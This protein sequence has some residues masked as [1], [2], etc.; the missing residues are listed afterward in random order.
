[1]VVTILKVVKAEKAALLAVRAARV[2]VDVIAEVVL[3]VVVA[4]MDPAVLKAAAE[5]LPDKYSGIL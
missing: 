1:M 4:A 5:A 3:R 2:K